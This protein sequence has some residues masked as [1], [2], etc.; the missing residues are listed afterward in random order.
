MESADLLIHSKPA[1]LELITS[2][3]NGL[4]EII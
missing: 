2:P 3:E 4:L 1:I